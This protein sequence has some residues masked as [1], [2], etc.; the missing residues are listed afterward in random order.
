MVTHRLRTIRALAVVLKGKQM[1]DARGR[2]FVVAVLLAVMTGCAGGVALE[3]PASTPSVAPS[4]TAGP[5]VTPFP[6]EMEP[7]AI[8]PGTYRIPSSAWS[9]TDFTVNFPEGWSVQYGH[10]YASNT[11]GDDEFGF[12]AVVVDDIFADA[13]DGTTGGLMETGP[14]VSDL[15][16]ALLQQPGPEASDPV[17]TTLGGYPAV[18]ID[19]K[20][21]QGFDLKACTLEG[22]G[23]QI[24]YSPP[25]DKYLV[26]LADGSA[27]VYILEV[28]GAR[29]VFM[30]QHR[31]ATSDE[32]V[33]E[34]QTVLDSIHIEP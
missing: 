15:A 6:N 29:Q 24:W 25:A 18:R 26:L 3:L 2:A 13:C 21:P 1:Q 34:L 32:D 4:P 5:T 20:V 16:A 19:L 12:Y 28:D 23:L 30:T 10:V 17:D 31:S 11:D 27:S 7:V 22:S 9:V 14:S 33:Q 8:E